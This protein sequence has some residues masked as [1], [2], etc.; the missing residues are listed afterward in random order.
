MILAAGFAPRRD[1]HF[2]PLFDAFASKGT[3]PLDRADSG[4]AWTLLENAS[5]ARLSIIGGR[6]T[7][8]ASAA[9]VRAGYIEANL[10]DSVARIGGTFVL[11][12]TSNPGG[13][14]AVFAVWKRRMT[15]TSSVPDGLHLVVSDTNW[16]LGYYQ[17]GSLT[18]LVGS[19]I[20]L[21][22]DGET[23]HEVSMDI[24]GST[25]TVN[26]VDGS[27]SVTDA[28]VS[29][30]VGPHACFE[31]YQG[32]AATDARAAFIEVYAS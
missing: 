3:A 21:A 23:V 19:A 28:I 29:S 15:S 9:S 2:S 25:V 4:H 1:V 20:S 10:G 22:A 26:T 5:E 6:L 8:A 24:S 14:V 7:N 18:E 12:P 32:N 16:S 13:G 31:V 11:G 17:S 27:T 30:V